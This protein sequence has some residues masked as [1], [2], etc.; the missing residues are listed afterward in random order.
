MFVFGNLLNA[1]AMLLGWV[2]T[3]ATYILIINALLSWVRPDPQNPIVRFLDTVSDALC[4]PIRRLFPTVFGGIDIAPL[5]VL[6][7]IQFVGS[8]F[9]VPT[10]RDIAFKMR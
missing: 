10:L 6:L 8:N 5:I 3:A 1:L 4:N 7:A 9:L 2:F